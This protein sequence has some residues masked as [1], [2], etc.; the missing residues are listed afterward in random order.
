M[1]SIGR[2]AVVAL[3]AMLTVNYQCVLA[4]FVLEEGPQSPMFA[5]VGDTVVFT[6]DF[7][8]VGG[9]A[10]HWYFKETAS[11]LSFNR[12]IY[13]RLPDVL[14]NRLAII[15]DVDQEQFNLRIHDVRMSDSGTYICQYAFEGGLATN[16]AMSTLTVLIPPSP[17]SP[18]CRVDPVRGADTNYRVGDSVVLHC[19]SMDGSPTPQVA[20]RRADSDAVLAGPASYI[21]HQYQLKADDN[22]LDFTCTMTTPALNQPKYC[23]VRPLIISPRAQVTPSNLTVREGNR[24]SLDCKGF[25]EPNIANYR[26]E[27]RDNKTGRELPRNR[28][29]VS[30]NSSSVEIVSVQGDIA[31]TCFVTTPS[32]LS[33]NSTVWI[34]LI[35]DSGQ[36]TVDLTAAG[37]EVD[38]STTTET[39]VVTT[40]LFNSTPPAE[41]NT[42][43]PVTDHPT[44]AT[45][46]FTLI[47][48][49][50][51]AFLAVIFTVLIICFCCM[52]RR[53][54]KRSPPRE[55]Y[56]MTKRG[57]TYEIIP[58]EPSTTQETNT[59]VQ[60]Q[61]E[62][63]T[64][65][66]TPLYAAPRKPK[67][68]TPQISERE[69]YFPN[70]YVPLYAT[71]NQRRNGDIPSET[72]EGSAKRI[73]TDT[74]LYAQPN[75]RA[76][77]KIQ[78]TISWGLD[79]N[80]YSIAKPKHV[81]KPD[82]GVQYADL[83]IGAESAASL[84][85]RP[86]TS[87]GEQTLYAQ[88]LK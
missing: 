1:L 54:N 43:H 34:E 56:P 19:G 76:K 39:S 53:K 22:G 5:H 27:I 58:T 18:E 14:K 77:K 48:A 65:T 2:G 78:S 69:L 32:G 31:V 33:G 8:D 21:A 13:R 40:E 63:N 60:M 52:R 3:I 30:W 50:A 10:I 70:S 66:T 17:Q 57:N 9:R 20:Y 41:M 79:E 38:I 64:V 74:S 81:R 44:E 82:S 61:S 85:E 62:S 59:V 24:V 25:G 42:R 47:I 49:V 87:A 23:S 73:P 45:I 12:V 80:G 35:D 11:Y 16:A 71:P 67:R 26:W 68:G 84:T 29:M 51:V 88:I 37:T 4:M 55:D 86:Q 28:Y 36:T 15:G 46:P 7:R 75:K 83:D 72:A 6:C